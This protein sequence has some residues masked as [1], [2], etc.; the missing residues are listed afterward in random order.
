MT[1]SSFWFLIVRKNFGD[2]AIV[3]WIVGPIRDGVGSKVWRKNGKQQATSFDVL[4]KFSVAP[5]RIRIRL[6]LIV[7]LRAT[8]WRRIQSGRLFVSKAFFIIP[9]RGS[10]YRRTAELF[11]V[12]RPFDCRNKFETKRLRLSSAAAAKKRK[13]K[14]KKKGNKK[15]KKKKREKE[16]SF[17]SAAKKHQ[18]NIPMHSLETVW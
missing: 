13:E 2:L 17:P 9:L 15:K 18:E 8:K 12:D 5:N 16:P 3:W 1:W 6:R 11:T 10:N 14:T 4:V 7:A